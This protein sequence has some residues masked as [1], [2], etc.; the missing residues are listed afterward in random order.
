M[1]HLQPSGPGI[2]VIACKS[3]GGTWG[4]IEELQPPEERLQQLSSMARKPKLII[5]CGMCG[6]DQ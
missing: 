1:R 6:R 3:C 4:H 5:V 2:V